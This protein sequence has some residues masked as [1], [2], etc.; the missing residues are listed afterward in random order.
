MEV[1]ARIAITVTAA[2][3]GSLIGLAFKGM[4]GAVMGFIVTLLV[5]KLFSIWNKYGE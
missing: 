4:F 5:I 2:I 3:V 1:T